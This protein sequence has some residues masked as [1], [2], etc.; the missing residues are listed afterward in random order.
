MRTYF[1]LS[2]SKDTIPY[3]TGLEV[4]HVSGF[5]CVCTFAGTLCVALQ[6]LICLS[7][8][9]RREEQTVEEK[10]VLDCFTRT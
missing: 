10:V 2:T 4:Y 3:G 7:A 1:E 9:G 6:V 8:N 5:I